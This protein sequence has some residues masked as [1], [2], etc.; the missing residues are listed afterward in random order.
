MMEFHKKI[1]GTAKRRGGAW[2]QPMH[3]LYIPSN[4]EEPLSKPPQRPLQ[5][6]FKT[7]PPNSLKTPVSLAPCGI[8]FVLKNKAKKEP[9]LHACLFLT[10]AAY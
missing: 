1:W 5:E 2:T 7:P 9:L 3:P 4:A 10:G 6:A 8:G